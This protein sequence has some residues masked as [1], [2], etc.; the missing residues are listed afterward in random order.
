MG[1]VV[2]IETSSP[3]TSVAVLR[4]GHVL[5]Q[6]SHDDP[7]AHAEVIAELFAEHVMP[8]VTSTSVDAV[9]CGVGPGPY[10]GLRVGVS[11]ARALA[12]AWSVPVLGVCSLDVIAS[13][14]WDE[15]E[16]LGVSTDAR[17][18]ERYWAIYRKGERVR[19]P[20]VSPDPEN[21][22]DARWITDDVPSA[23]AAVRLAESHGLAVPP[24]LDFDVDDHGASG[25]RTEIALR[26]RVLLPAVPLY[27][28]G[29]DVTLS[30][31]L[32]HP[33]IDVV[34]V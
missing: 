11:F 6:G 10:S 17:R 23:A 13:E 22:H 31:R 32:T 28:R 5:G 9:V 8:H 18:K 25:E 24:A 7:R 3:V 4:D 2:G 19:G 27:L 21:E 16:V 1:L 30:N 33:G 29:A 34:W 14:H 20:R 12:F 26:G 15:T